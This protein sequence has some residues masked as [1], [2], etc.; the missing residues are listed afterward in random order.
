MAKIPFPYAT[1]TSVVLIPQDGALARLAARILEAHGILPGVQAL[2]RQATQTT[3]SVPPGVL[4]LLGPF[5]SLALTDMVVSFE[6]F[7]RSLDHELRLLVANQFPSWPVPKLPEKPYGFFFYD[8][9]KARTH[10]KGIFGVNVFSRL[11]YTKLLDWVQVRHCFA[12]AN[13]FPGTRGRRLFRHYRIAPRQRLLIRVEVLDE[14]A[15]TI[16]ESATYVNNRIGE[17]AVRRVLASRANLRWSRNRGAFLRLMSVLSYFGTLER[18]E[19][20]LASLY[21]ILV[22]RHF[23]HREHETGLPPAQ[24]PLVVPWNA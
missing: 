9:G 7:L 8:L 18:G 11:P 16:Q 19:D 2:W 1:S 21:R 4:E 20:Y 15:S 12:H 24:R 6:T 23:A 5:A 22:A 10:F 14:A 13:G 3:A 17:V